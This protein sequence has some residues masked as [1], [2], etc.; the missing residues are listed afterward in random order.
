MIKQF[1]L[2]LGQIDA[3][4]S[5]GSFLWFAV[6][7]RESPPL[8]FSVELLRIDAE[9]GQ[10]HTMLDPTSV[11]VT[12]LGWPLQASPVD[13][14]RFAA[15]TQSFSDIEHWWPRESDGQMLALSEGLSDASAEL[16]GHWPTVTLRL[17]F[18]HEQW[19][20]IR[21][22]HPIEL[23]DELGRANTERVHNAGWQLAESLDGGLAPPPRDAVDGELWL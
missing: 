3:G 13:A 8:S 6:R 14:G 16:I 5:D 23:F 20:G 15:D 11:D 17:S 10:V 18:N 1:E 4:I 7:R 21:L 12:G 19:P 2:G 22:I 9:S